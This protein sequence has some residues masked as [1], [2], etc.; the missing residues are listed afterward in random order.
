MKVGVAKPE[1]LGTLPH[2]AVVEK[3]KGAGRPLQLT[4]VA[5]TQKTLCPLS[6]SRTNPCSS[7]AHKLLGRRQ[8][9]DGMYCASQHSILRSRSCLCSGLSNP[10]FSFG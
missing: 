2:K 5:G 9:S 1:T 4:F 10:C 7:F 8:L 3:L 6:T